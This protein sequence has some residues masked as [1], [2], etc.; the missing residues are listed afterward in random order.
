MECE[1]EVRLNRIHGSTNDG[2][3]IMRG[4]R[5]QNAAYS[6]DWDNRNSPG[7]ADGFWA[8]P[9]TPGAPKII[10]E[11][12]FVDSRDAGH[13]F[14]SITGSLTFMLP[15]TQFHHAVPT[16]ATFLDGL[17]VRHNLLLSHR[18]GWKMVDGFKGTK[19][20]NDRR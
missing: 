11:Y 16:G 9:M 5:A 6:Q 8:A 12:N 15:P 14:N 4:V 7:H 17:L 3:T 13:G 20:P 18:I 10:M 1:S 19:V 2:I